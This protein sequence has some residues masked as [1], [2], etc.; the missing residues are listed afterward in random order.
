MR[1]KEVEEMFQKI[2]LVFLMAFPPLM[3]AR[4]LPGKMDVLDYYL[5]LPEE[6]FRCELETTV[7]AEYR[8]KQIQR[9]NQKNGFI[10]ARSEGYPMEVALFRDQVNGRDIVAVNIYCGDGCMCNKLE[11][12][13]LTAAGDWQSVR[14]SVFPAEDEIDKAL[15]RDSGWE[16]RLPEF[17][18]TITIVERNTGKVILQLPW[19]N[20]RFVIKA[21]GLESNLEADAQGKSGKIDDRFPNVPEV[22]VMRRVIADSKRRIP[23]AVLGVNPFKIKKRA[24]SGI[25]MTVPGI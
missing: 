16:Y 8:Q 19:L 23:F 4:D 22:R 25:A 15:K 12:F 13:V 18:T 17:G 9:L 10:L 11:F 20:S 21:S 1:D 24:A 5:Q 3:S 2:F 14:E 6:L 7:S